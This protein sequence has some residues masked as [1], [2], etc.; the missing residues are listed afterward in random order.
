MRVTF[1]EAPSRNDLVHF[2][3]K[4]MKWGVRNY[5]DKNG[6]LTPEGRK[7]YAEKPLTKHQQKLSTKWQER[8]LSKADA[9]I[10]AKRRAEVERLLAVTGGVTAAAAT[11]YIVSKHLDRTT[12][13]LLGKGSEFGRVATNN[14]KNMEDAFYVFD[15]A[16]DRSKYVGMY[17]KSL[18]DQGGTSIFEKSLKAVG[19][20]K[21]ASPETGRKAFANL[22]SRDPEVMAYAKEAFSQKSLLDPLDNRRNLYS[23]ALNDINNGKWTKS[24][25]EAFNIGLVDHSEAGNKVASKF[26]N[27]LK[28]DGFS[29][30][31]DVNDHSFSGYNSKNPLIIFDKDKVDVQ[32]AKALSNDVIDKTNNMAAGDL[33]MSS[34][35]K[36]IAKVGVAAVGIHVV[37]RVTSQVAEDN[38]IKNYLKAHPNTKL[39][40]DGIL[41]TRGLE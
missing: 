9:D 1:D 20:V 11:A 16:K 23:K 26:Y 12:D 6:R 8:G 22:I 5:T 33:L 19:D 17:A 2:G 14:S 29:A 4:G 39:N 38:Y 40:R 31:R 21:V 10:Q 24:A 37:N 7:H 27:Q 30:I 35:T 18:K 36:G 34:I 25:Y 13:K 41:K 15:N 3:V 28:K 32:S